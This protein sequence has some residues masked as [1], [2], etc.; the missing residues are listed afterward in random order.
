MGDRHQNQPVPS[1]QPSA[2]VS[3]GTPDGIIFASAARIQATYTSDEI[4]NPNCKG[5]RL[6]F[7]SADAG[8]GTATVQ[9][10]VRDP[11]SDNWV[12]ILTGVSPAWTGNQSRTLTIYPGLPAV[13]G[14]ATTNTTANDFVST[15][16]RITVVVGTAT[17]TFSI[18]AEHLL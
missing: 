6:Y 14:I 2:G 9:V 16:W 18:G 17:L 13:A 12:N 11:N 1:P 8:A 15:S 10:Q 7:S 3:S 4:Y 5:I